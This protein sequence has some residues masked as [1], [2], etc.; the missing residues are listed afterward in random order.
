MIDCQYVYERVI[1]SD[2]ETSVCV[3]YDAALTSTVI[4]DAMLRFSKSSN[5]RL[6]NLAQIYLSV[7][8]AST[9]LDFHASTTVSVS[10]IRICLTICTRLPSLRSAARLTPQCTSATALFSTT[11][12]LVAPR[13]VRATIGDRTFPAA[14]A[15]V[16]NS[17][18]ES[19]RASPSLQVFRS[20]L[21]TEL[22]ARSYSCSD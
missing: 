9:A 10:P 14:A 19:A 3:V 2:S 15:S 22:F 7:S 13:T 8:F 20:R 11:S 18:P 5:P 12:A 1:V 17:L 21:K 16:W 4:I 6:G